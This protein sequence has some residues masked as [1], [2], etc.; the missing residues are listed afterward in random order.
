MVKFWPHPRW[1]H[2]S[3]TFQLS[4]VY[5]N[6]PPKSMIFL[7]SFRSSP[8]QGFFYFE[9]FNS[10]PSSSSNS[11]PSLSTD[12][13]AII[14]SFTFITCDT[15]QHGQLWTVKYFSV[16]DPNKPAP[17]IV[18][19][20][21]RRHVQ[22]VHLWRSR[23]HFYSIEYKWASF[24]NEDGDCWTFNHPNSKTSNTFF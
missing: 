21:T 14:Y 19:N 3:L 4:E 23:P 11:S 24:S 5:Q 16:C 17:L 15:T 12:G 20:T 6:S 22:I 18:V 1:R 8:L 2:V 10:E 9:D 7:T 13:Y